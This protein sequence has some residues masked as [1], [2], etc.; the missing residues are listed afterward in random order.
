VLFKPSF[1]KNLLINAYGCNWIMG[2]DRQNTERVD[3]VAT[4]IPEVGLTH[5]IDSVG[6]WV[7][8]LLFSSFVQDST[9]KYAETISFQTHA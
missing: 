7:R 4:C 5:Q 8:F 9:F 2:A 1:Y 3:V 6:L